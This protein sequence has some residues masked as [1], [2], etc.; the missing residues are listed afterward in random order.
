VFVGGADA[1][2]GGISSEINFENFLIV[3]MGSFIR[4]CKQ[5]E[6]RTW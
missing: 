4:W 1:I 3:D 2:G 6:L 5:V